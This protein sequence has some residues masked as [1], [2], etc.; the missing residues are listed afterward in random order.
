MCLGKID[1]YSE[2][3]GR[4][5][6]RYGPAAW[7]LIYQADVRCR[8]EHMERARRRG[9]EERALALAA[10]GTHPL[11]PTRPWDWGWGEVLSDTDFWR[12]ELE[13]PALLAITRGIKSAPSSENIAPAQPGKRIT[14]VSN[15]VPAKRQRH[16]QPGDGQHHVKN[17]KGKLLCSDFNAG[18]CKSGGAGLGELP[19][20][21]RAGPSV[22]PPCCRGW[23]QRP[24][25][26]Q[27]QRQTTTRWILT[28]SWRC[29]SSRL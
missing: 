12:A 28:S 22:G 5:V 13:E 16:D 8:S 11:D 19:R 14:D 20:A 21:F 17:R 4:Y 15:D 18:R 10:G 6:S 29:W 3:I 26:G 1:R 7:L 24:G 27:G 2:L 9:E 25:Q 23:R